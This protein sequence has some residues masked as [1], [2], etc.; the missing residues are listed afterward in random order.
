MFTELDGGILQQQIHD[1]D[2]GV[3]IA[4]IGSHLNSFV[5]SQQALDVPTLFFN[6]SPNDLT[7]G[8]N[9]TRMMFPMCQAASGNYKKKSCDFEANQLT[10][11]VW[12]TIITHTPDA[13]HV[14]SN[15]ELTQDE[16]DIMLR[17]YSLLCITA[18]KSTTTESLRR[19]DN[20][21][22]EIACDWIKNNDH[23]WSQWIPKNLSSKTPIYIGGLFPLT[24]PHWRQPAIVP[25]MHLA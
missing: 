5:R 25:G 20:Y 13:Y 3:S 21:L 15:M 9:F 4:M 6:W 8:N 16:L 18:S 12:N 24:G 22:D 7:A 23:L 2:L 19:S 11:I 1:L 17:R 10:K 14:I